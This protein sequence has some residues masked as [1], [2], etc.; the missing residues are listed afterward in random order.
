M[1]KDKTVALITGAN[2]GIGF[3]I[4][5]Q[6]GKK[7]FH[8]I[9]SGRKEDKINMAAA[10]LEKQGISAEPLLMDISDRESI[11]IAREKIAV[12]EVKLSVLVNNAAVL[13]TEDTNIFQDIS[14]LEKTLQTNVYGAIQVTQIFL[15]LLEKGA[16]IVNISSGGGSLTDNTGGWSPAYCVSK[17]LLNSVT[18][19]MAYFLSEKSIAVNAVC[20][21][22]VQTD[23]GG[24]NA[25][26]TVEKGAETP[27]W[28]CTEAPAHYTGLFF[29]D[30]QIIPW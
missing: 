9:V 23:M 3:E 30:K 15:P 4:A 19:Q 28:L 20:P 22:W 26:R 21:G 2:K 12:N 5:R 11:E 8:I 1:N 14:I 6:L 27:V 29:R 17:T 24:R 10:N 16:R 18:K 25:P 13:L 7:G